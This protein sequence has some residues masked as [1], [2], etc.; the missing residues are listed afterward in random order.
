VICIPLKLP[1]GVDEIS[2]GISS[3]MQN[4]KLNTTSDIL[5]SNLIVSEL[6]S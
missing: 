5:F 4:H 6:H 2:S 1:L 3:A